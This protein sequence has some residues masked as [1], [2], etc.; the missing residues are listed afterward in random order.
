M[1]KKADKEK[2]FTLVEVLVALAV[3]AISLTALLQLYLNSTKLTYRVTEEFKAVPVAVEQ[4][5][6]IKNTRMLSGM[7][8]EIQDYTVTAKPQTETSDNF[9]YNVIKLKVVR[10]NTELMELYWLDITDIEAQYKKELM[11]ELNL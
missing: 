5:E 1:K 6:E 7:T 10:N 9:T 11:E 3:A 4:M 8:K 2:G